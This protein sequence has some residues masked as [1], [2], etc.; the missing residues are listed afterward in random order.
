V[1]AAPGVAQGRTQFFN[2][3]S[4]GTALALRQVDVKTPSHGEA[5]PRGRREE[6]HLGKE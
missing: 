3:S 2:V 4:V 6:H 1:R 5:D